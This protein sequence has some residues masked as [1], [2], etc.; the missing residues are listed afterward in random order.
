LARRQLP[1]PTD[2]E[3][4]VQEIFI[5]I[6]RNA[7]RFDEQ[8]AS[9]V[10]FVAMIARRRLI[11]RRRKQK[12]TIET[13]P[14]PSG[15]DP[16]ESREPNQTMLGEEVAAAREQLKLLR[17]E[18]RNVLEL[19]IDKGWTQAQVAESLKMPLGTVKTNA[20]RGLMRL[21]ELFGQIRGEKVEAGVQ[22]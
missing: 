7:S 21:R 1:N 8:I 11:D 12:S 3:D 15:L 14:L 9:E 6:W 20:R 13:R 10:T 16:A 5:D 2:A 4:A 19:A 17:P 22:R 18:E